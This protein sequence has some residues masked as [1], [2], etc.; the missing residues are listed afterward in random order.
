MV[1]RVAVKPQARTRAGRKAAAVIPPPQAVDEEVF[2]QISVLSTDSAGNPTSF[3]VYHKGEEIG[4]VYVAY[5][6]AM[7]NVKSL[8]QQFNKTKARVMP[9]ISLDKNRSAHDKKTYLSK[10][11]RVNATGLLGIAVAGKIVK[12]HSYSL[13]SEADGQTGAYFYEETS[14]TQLS[15]TWVL[16]AREGVVKP[17]VSAPGKLFK[18]ATQ[19]KDV[20][21]NLAAAVYVNYEI[22]YS[23]DDAV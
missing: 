3:R 19:G 14:G 12:V 20:G 17:F 13:Q 9:V 16:N 23:V 11:G 4:K 15:Q 10:V 18:T 22:Q 8:V 1:R 7:L 21:L 6:D 5:D 2:D